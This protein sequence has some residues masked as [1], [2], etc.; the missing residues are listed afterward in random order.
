MTE[1]TEFFKPLNP[2]MGIADNA[3]KN[4][5]A[6]ISMADALA[7]STNQSV[8]IKDYNQKAFLHVSSNPLFLCGYSPQQVQQM[9][10]A[11]YNQVVPEDETAIL[12]EINNA[13]FELYYKLPL[14]ERLGIAVQ[15]DFHLKHPN[16]K[17]ILINHKLTPILLSEQGDIWVALCM[18]SLSPRTKVG[19][20]AFSTKGSTTH[21]TYS[22][23]GKRWKE[24]ENISLND[25]ETDILRL[26]SQGYSMSEIAERLFIDVN[27][28]KFHRKNLFVKL[29]AKNITEAIGIAANMRLI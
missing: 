20:V 27:T 14:E 8:Y 13:G 18:V 24:V 12:Y 21:F 22:F 9:G 26:A 10:F 23:E 15:Y 2:N 25:R 1:T 19:N 11:F 29:E 7:R 5:E 17:K 3:Y 28:V 16:G 4:L 6:C